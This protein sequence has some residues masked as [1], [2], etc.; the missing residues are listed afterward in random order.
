M[1]IMNNIYSRIL[2]LGTA[3]LLAVSCLEKV[4]GDYVPIDKGMNT[5]TDA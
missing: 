5:V 3:F 1:M 2:I 4:P